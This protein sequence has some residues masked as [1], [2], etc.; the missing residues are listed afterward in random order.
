MKN[1]LG[2]NTFKALQTGDLDWNN[3]TVCVWG[4]CKCQ[5]KAWLCFKNHKKSILRCN[6]KEHNSGKS[7]KRSILRGWCSKRGSET[8]LLSLKLEKRLEVNFCL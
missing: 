4:G 3:I 1:M 6:L 8:W 5:T 2:K 7:L